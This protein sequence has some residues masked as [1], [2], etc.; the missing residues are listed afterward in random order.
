[1]ILVVCANP[2]VDTLVEL[3]TVTPGEVHRALSE[4]RYPGGKGTHVALALRELGADVT[5]LGFWGGPT[6]TWVREECQ[7]L[8]IRCVGP[9]LA[10][11]TR[12]C[13]TILAPG[14]FADTEILGRG[15]DYSA[16]VGKEFFE[17]FDEVARGCRGLVISGSALPGTPAGFYAEL[18]A[19]SPAG[20]HGLDCGGELFTEACRQQLD[21][22]HLNRAEARALTGLDPEPAARALA[23]RI[24]LVAVTAG[25]EGLFLQ[26]ADEPTVHARVKLERVLSAVGSGDCLTAGIAFAVD[27]GLAVAD[28]ARWGVACGAANCLRPELGMLHAADVNELLKRVQ[29]NVIDK[30]A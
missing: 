5:L 1:M 25:A 13:Q 16:A 6:G 15:P 21:F 17:V 3:G 18:L 8:G 29:V 2:A 28:I 7:K 19:R 10:E 12:T 23:R 20:F 24:P 27:R 22:I 11:W 4:R 26:K 30:G 14:A 9:Q